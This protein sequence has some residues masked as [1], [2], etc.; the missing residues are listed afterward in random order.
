MRITL[1]PAQHNVDG[2]YWSYL[3][4][5][6]LASW[7]R[8]E[9]T[10]CLEGFSLSTP[11]SEYS[12]VV[13]HETGHTM[14]FPHEHMRQEIIEKLDHEKTIEYFQRVYHWTPQ[15]TIQQVLT[16]LDPATLEATRVGDEN[17]IMCYQLSGECTVDGQPIAGG[18]EI[19]LIDKHFA[20][21]IYPK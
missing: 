12:R 19:D 21:S 1:D 16:P 8:G 3:G 14:G 10:M 15:E 2:G 18:T 5:T 4:T 13:C 6:I 20:A 9:P 17:S 7:L 11:D